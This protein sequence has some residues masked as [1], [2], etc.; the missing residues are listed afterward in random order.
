MD[1]RTFEGGLRDLIGEGKELRPFVCD[2][3]PL[4][5]KAF[6]VGTNP[7]TGMKSSFWHYWDETTGFCKERWREEYAA[8]RGACGDGDKRKSVSPTRKRINEIVKAAAPSGS[9][10]RV[11][12]L[13]TNLFSSAT[14]REK[15]LPAAQKRTEVFEYLSYAISPKVVFAHGKPVRRYFERK[16]RIQLPLDGGFADVSLNGRRR[17][18]FAWRHLSRAKWPPG[19]AEKIGHAIR[20]GA[21]D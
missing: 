2:G 11:S 17:R 19:A 13:E 10:G 20:E 7:A 15:D 1:L 8:Q 18:I 16:F 4:Q 9:A 21:V 5:C 14:Q 6:I 3:D 12:V